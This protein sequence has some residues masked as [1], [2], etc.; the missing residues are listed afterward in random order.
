MH[1][2]PDAYRCFATV[3]AVLGMLIICW[4]VMNVLGGD[5]E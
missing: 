4:V 2:H 5:E 1:I 3:I